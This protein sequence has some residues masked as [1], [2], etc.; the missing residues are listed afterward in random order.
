MTIKIPCFPC[1]VV[2]LSPII[3]KGGLPWKLPS[4]PRLS[5]CLSFFVFWPHHVQSEPWFG[6]YPATLN[7][8]PKTPTSIPLPS[9]N[10]EE[11]LGLWYEN[12]IK[13]KQK[14]HHFSRKIVMYITSSGVFPSTSFEMLSISS[15]PN[16]SF[17]FMNWLKS[18]FDQLVKPCFSNSSF[19]A[20]SSSVKGS[21]W[22]V[23]FCSSFRVFS[24]S[25]PRSGFLGTLNA[26]VQIPVTS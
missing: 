2:T 13:S 21:A 25:D 14:E 23:F 7:I 4:H 10:A 12:H 8:F 11:T 1:A 18:L 19:S 22:S 20:C 6:L 15:R 5:W 9:K 16:L 17:A 26:E 3:Q 24:A